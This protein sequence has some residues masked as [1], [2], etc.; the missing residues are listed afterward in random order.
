[1]PQLENRISPTSFVKGTRGSGILRYSKEPINPSEGTI[2]LWFYT[3]SKSPQSYSRLF[4]IGDW[5]SD[6]SRDNLEIRWGSGWN[7]ADNIE[8][9]IT[10]KGVVRQGLN[11]G[12]IGITP[13]TWYYIAV[14]WKTGG[15]MSM[16]LINNT[17]GV[18]TYKEG[19]L[20]NNPTFASEG[21]FS[22]GS[23]SGL[24]NGIIDELRIDRVQRSAEEVEGW[25]ISRVPF[26]PKGIHRLAY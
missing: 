22:V 13:Y 24:I 1:M 12:V 14:T 17:T 4:Q 20:T 11:T 2:S 9:E 5:T 6:V 7:N 19:N 3:G 25:Y 21:F 26:Y 10:Q 16:T 15:K 23:G 8:F 18:K